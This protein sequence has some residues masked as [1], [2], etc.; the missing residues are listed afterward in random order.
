[1]K[2]FGYKFVIALFSLLIF[3]TAAW[4]LE[5]TALSFN[6]NGSST[7]HRQQNDDWVLEL[8]SIIEQSNAHIVLLQEVAIPLQKR[9]DTAYFK[10]AQKN[11]VLDTLC[12]LLGDG[13]QY[14]SSANYGIRKSITVGDEIYREGNMTQN[15]AILYNSSLLHADDWAERLGFTTFSGDYLFDKN[16]VQ[17]IAFSPVETS[18]ES[19]TVLVM[20]VHLPYNNKEHQARDVQTVESLYA[21]YKVRY[22][23]LIGGDFNI[24]R[25]DLVTRNFDF[26]DG[27]DSWYYDRNFGLKTTLSRSKE[28]CFKLANDYD[29][30]VYNARL[31]VRGKTELLFS[32]TRSD[33][34]TSV[35]LGTCVYT[36]SKEFSQKIS[37]H[38]PIVIHF[39][40]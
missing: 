35:Q 16:T 34:Y 29:H 11:N 36:S 17:V 6:V 15:N 1:M 18:A 30:F 40:L 8:Y 3:V 4:A 13:W 24:H 38:A 9:Y 14:C 31:V 32:H 5:L 20:N 10:T 25:K 37:D 7:E 12:S 26:V 33:Y 27:S 39:T 21:R 19:K 22:P 23:I 28:D 2:R